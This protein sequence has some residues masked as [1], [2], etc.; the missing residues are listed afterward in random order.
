MR[1]RLNWYS[2]EHWNL[3][4]WAIWRQLLEKY[5][6]YKDDKKRYLDWYFDYEKWKKECE[7][8]GDL[9]LIAKKQIKEYES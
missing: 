1:S 4:A 2:L 3:A 9:R 6:C 7:D 5:G 8:I